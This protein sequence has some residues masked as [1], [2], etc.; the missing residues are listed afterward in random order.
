MKGDRK[1]G[2]KRCPLTGLAGSIDFPAV[3]FSNFLAD[4][5]ADPGSFVQVM[6]M[7]PLKDPEDLFG[8]LLFESYAVI[9]N[10]NLNIAR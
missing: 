10:R 9:S 4:G 8:I 5:Q 3:I 7:Q 1:N 2:S 6:S